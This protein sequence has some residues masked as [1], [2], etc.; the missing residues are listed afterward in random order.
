MEWAID[1]LIGA[2]KSFWNLLIIAVPLIVIMQFMKEYKLMDKVSKFFRKPCQAIGLDVKTVYPLLA[3]LIFGL[4]YGSGLILQEKEDSNIPV[5]QMTAICLF[6]GLCH[7]AFE[8][9]LLFWQVGASGG[10]ILLVRLAV[11]LPLLILFL[12]FTA[13]KTTE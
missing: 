2:F 1:V 9:H 7:S 8:D 4:T 11:T 13:P 5:R 3:G 10:I 12:R 6:L